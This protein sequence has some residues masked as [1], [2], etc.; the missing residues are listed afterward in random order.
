MKQQTVLIVDDEPRSRRGLKRTLEA[1]SPKLLNVQTAASAK[2]AITRLNE[3]TIDL[4]ITDIRMP[5]MSGLHLV[6]ALQEQN[7]KPVCI[8]ISAYSEF[9][10][11]HTALELGVRHYLLKPVKKEKLI[12]AV[13]SALQMKKEQDRFG[14]VE[15]VW[16]E[17]IDAIEKERLSSSDSIHEALH[18]IDAH[19]DQKIG[20]K[21]VAKSVHLNPSYLSALFKEKTN[22]TFSEYLTRKRLQ[23]AKHLLVST[24]RPIGDIAEKCGYQT[25]KYFIKIFKEHEGMTPT[26]YRKGTE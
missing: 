12:E 14:Q 1:W 17:K 9:E 13:E 10:Y 5:E 2:E 21:D 18:Y 4:L 24:D 20:L 11:A 7:P 8:V 22:M 6:K 15:K 19:L 26:Q 23:H 3:E 16:D 25:A